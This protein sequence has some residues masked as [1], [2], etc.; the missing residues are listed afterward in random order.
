MDW[1]DGD[2]I[3]ISFD[4]IWQNIFDQYYETVAPYEGLE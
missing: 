4:N 3:D 1:F 2:E